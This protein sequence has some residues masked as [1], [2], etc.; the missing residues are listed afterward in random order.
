MAD[1]N[2]S[3]K[4]KDYVESPFSLVLSLYILTLLSKGHFEQY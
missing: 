2:S 1:S 4:P 3:F